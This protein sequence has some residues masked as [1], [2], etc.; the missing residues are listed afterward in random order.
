M[1]HAATRRSEQPGMVVSTENSLRISGQNGVVQNGRGLAPRARS[2]GPHLG[3]FT[4]LATTPGATNGEHVT[5]G[6]AH[7]A[8]VSARYAHGR[9]GAPSSRY[10]II[11]TGLGRAGAPLHMDAPVGQVGNAGTEHIVAGVRHQHFGCSTGA[12][13]EDGRV[14]FA[15]VATKLKALVSRPEEHVAVRQVGCCYGHHRNGLRRAPT[16]KLGHIHCAL[17]TPRLAGGAVAGFLYHLRAL[18][19][20]C[21]VQRHAQTAVPGDQSM[22]AALRTQGELL[23]VGDLAIP[24]NHCS[25]GCRRG[26]IHIQA[27]A[28]AGHLQADIFACLHRRPLLVGTAVAAPLNDEGTCHHRVFVDVQTLPRGDGL[29]RSGDLRVGHGC[30]K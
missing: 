30:G 8:L 3:I 9:T 12:W 10:R 4:A 13:V 27:H 18:H 19:G 25:T 16:A 24:L 5:I 23:V 20:R 17:H 29:Y 22:A 2:Q 21:R 15:V 26:T 7:A 1:E 28:A 6:Q 14:S 11:N